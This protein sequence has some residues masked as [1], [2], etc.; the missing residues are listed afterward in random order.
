MK[1]RPSK[2]EYYLG[3]AK[4]VAKRSTCLR[5]RYGAVIVNHDQ[6]ISTGYAGAPRGSKNCIDVGHCPREK[7]GVP[8]GERY[9]LCRSVHAE[10]N[11]VIHAARTDMADGTVYLVGLAPD[12]DT[13]LE[14]SEPCRLCKR[15]IINAG[16][17]YVHAQQGENDI[18]KFVVETW[19][20][21]EDL[22]LENARGY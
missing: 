22:D 13:Y 1:K 10:M 6:I 9:E 4:E 16:L 18:K 19:I 2:E 20:S 15:V 5:R 3:I 21:D 7:A 8:S 11:A 17:K 14:D 12:S